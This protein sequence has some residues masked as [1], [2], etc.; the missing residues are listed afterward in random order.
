[1]WLYHLA[2]RKK[3][4]IYSIYFILL[5]LGLLALTRM[6][7]TDSI[8]ATYSL[9]RPLIVSFIIVLIVISFYKSIYYTIFFTF[10]LGSVLII[11]LIF[12]ELSGLYFTTKENVAV[13]IYLIATSSVIG[14]YIL[15]NVG[16]IVNAVGRAILFST[17]FC[18]LLL[19]TKLF[20][21]LQF[22]QPAMLLLLL[23]GQIVAYFVSVIFLPII[24]NSPVHKEVCGQYDDLTKLNK[25][26][27]KRVKEV[28][29]SHQIFRLYILILLTMPSIYFL[30]QSNMIDSLAFIWFLSLFL[31]AGTYNSFRKSFIIHSLLLL[32]L[33]VV[34]I[35]SILLNY[36]EEGKL[37][38][39]HTLVY[40]ELLM[41][42][43]LSW[44]IGILPLLIRVYTSYN[45]GK[46]HSF[47]ILIF[48][49]A[50]LPIVGGLGSELGLKWFTFMMILGY[51]IV[52]TISTIY[53]PIMDAIL[54]KESKRADRPFNGVDN[55]DRIEDKI[56]KNYSDP[57]A[58]SV[59]DREKNLAAKYGEWLKRKEK[60]LE[61][62]S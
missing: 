45:S 32:Y 48:V 10:Q 17:A 60:R 29:R 23:I 3:I 57:V 14:L 22:L 38:L 26:E 46:L 25:E 18:S 37:I 13:Y 61:Q 27:N 36:F 15:E 12:V 24:S 35:S 39:N 41:G 6:G 4:L 54:Y 42:L 16:S 1:M 51:S 55:K 43:V 56:T 21:P 2:S 44:G 53:Y 58:I 47:S 50:L 28:K 20:I 31:L 19:V 34:V 33:P 7:Y 8:N 9:F 49:L 30:Y 5:F 11:S 40:P 52:N 62:E 59:E